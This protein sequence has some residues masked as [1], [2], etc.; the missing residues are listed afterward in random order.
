M[1]VTRFVKSM[2]YLAA[3]AVTLILSVIFQRSIHTSGTAVAFTRALILLFAFGCTF[4]GTAIFSYRSYTKIHEEHRFDSLFLLLCGAPVLLYSVVVFVN[5]GAYT[6]LFYAQTGAAVTNVTI[7]VMSAIPIPFMLR[8]I[9]L[10]ANRD[11]SPMQKRI[12]Y[13][14]IAVL[15]V[16]FILGA[17]LGGFMTMKRNIDL[18]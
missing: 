10:G 14:F 17:V 5:Y 16:M 3:G 7:T 4:V 6:D 11:N 8:G 13:V 2:A 12:F 1:R 18:L 15:G 9:L